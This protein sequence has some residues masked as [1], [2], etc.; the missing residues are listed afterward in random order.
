MFEFFPM[1]PVI[2]CRQSDMFILEVL[3][4][5]SVQSA[6]WGGRREHISW[7]SGIGA[8]IFISVENNFFT[9]DGWAP[10]GS[11]PGAASTIINKILIL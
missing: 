7:C 10:S 5:R 6:S 1:S 3:Q 4:G 2:T 11:C 8:D 9:G